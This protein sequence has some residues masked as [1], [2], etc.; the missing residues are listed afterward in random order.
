MDGFNMISEFPAKFWHSEPDHVTVCDLC[1]RA[2]RLK[3]DQRGFCFVRQNVNGAMVL[4]TYGRSSGFC[5]DPIEKK[6]FNHFHPGTSV[7]S[8][9]TAGCNMG[10]QFC[11]NWEISKSREMD[12][13]QRIAEPQEIAKSAVELGCRSVAFTYNDPVVFLEY[14]IDTAKY[15]R[16]AGLKTVG[17]TAGYIAESAYA[18]F[19]GCLDAVNI[20]IKGFTE[21]FYQDQ[22]AAQLQPVLDAIL[23]AKRQTDVWIELTTLL[24]PGLNDSEN[25]IMN[26]TE[27]IA[28]ELGV[29]IPLH[30]TAYTPSYRCTQPPTPSETLIRAREIAL[31]KGLR[32]VYTGNIHDPDTQSTYC[33]NCGQLLIGRDWHTV[34]EYDLVRINH[35][36]VCNTRIAG[37]FSRTKGSW[38]G[39]RVAV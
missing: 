2:C 26:L 19:F 6:P 30:F 21:R 11:Q 22:C 13:L 5:V 20:D 32:Y 8:F 34:T 33:P 1:P 9:G 39:Q 7:L 27:W 24:I 4:T 17:V 28:T 10:C 36:V 35:C 25:E 37:R 12:S 31:S 15:C 38:A 14:M 16:E 23:Y 18:D 3:P 29:D